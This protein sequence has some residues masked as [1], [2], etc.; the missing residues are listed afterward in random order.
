M[1]SLFDSLC[2]TLVIF[3]NLQHLLLGE[4]V[5]YFRDKRAY[6]F[7]ALTPMLGAIDRGR[8]HVSLSHLKL[9]TL[10]SACLQ[11]EQ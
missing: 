1:C 8:P 4:F 10:V 6:F 2:E 5:F 11:R 3:R 7:S 9:N